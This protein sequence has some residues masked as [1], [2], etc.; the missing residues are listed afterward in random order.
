MLSTKQQ[1]IINIIYNNFIDQSTTNHRNTISITIHAHIDIYLLLLPVLLHQ[2]VLELF[3]W[4]GRV[5]EGDL[6]VERINLHH[7]STICYNKKIIIRFLNS[8]SINFYPSFLIIL[9]CYISNCLLISTTAPLFILP[10][11]RY[12]SKEDTRI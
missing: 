10:A 11:F 5:D 12:D 9:R 6:Q 7:Q 4:L 3:C 1:F 2:F 8:L